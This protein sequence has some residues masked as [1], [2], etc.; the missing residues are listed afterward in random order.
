MEKLKLDVVSPVGQF[1]KDEKVPSIVVP[2]VKG[3]MTIL[4]GHRDILCLLGKGKLSVGKDIFVVYKGIMEVTNGTKVVIAAERIK[5][6]SEIDINKVYESIKEIEY[7]L[8]NVVL[9]DLSYKR[10]QEEYEDC[11]AELHAFSEYY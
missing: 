5:R 6:A 3:E 4:P 11:L 1:M 10:T 2:S 9:D 8:N 7:K